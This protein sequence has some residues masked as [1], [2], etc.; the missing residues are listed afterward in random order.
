[1]PFD[2]M[3]LVETMRRDPFALDADLEVPSEN[4]AVGYEDFDQPG[5]RFVERGFWSKLPK[6]GD[7]FFAVR[8]M[9]AV[10]K[11]QALLLNQVDRCAQWACLIN[12]VLGRPKKIVL[13][14]VFFSTP[15]AF[16][17][18]VVQRMV[19]GATWNVVFSEAQVIGF[20]REFGLPETRFV[21]VPYQS[22]H[23]KRPPLAEPVGDYVWAGGN[24]ARDYRT[25]I[26]AVKGTGI[27][28]QITSTLPELATFAAG[29]SEVTLAPAHEPEFTEL[30]AR[31]RFVVLPLTEGRVRGY[32]EQ[33]ILNSWWHGRAVLALDDVS[34]GDYVGGSGGGEVLNP[35]D[36]DGLRSLLQAWWADEEGT[37]T[38][39]RAG[40]SWV[41]A[42]YTHDHFKRRM[43]A[44]TRLCAGL[45]AP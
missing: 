2:L 27:P 39:G 25:L 38:C 6:V 14:D 11:T 35:G 42:R 8:L 44:V 30:M 43:V 33:T 32:G 41:A 5:Y 12:G 20:A 19:E 21:H 34:A 23:S 4:Q 37:R 31:S 13:Y 15:S 7:L 40:Q 26:E 3:S 1:M 22:S 28:V 17:R 10:R 29:V 16:R 24:S 9:L 45:T 18:R 36:V